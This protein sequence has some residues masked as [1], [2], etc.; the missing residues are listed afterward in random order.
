M[1]AEC[2]L[3]YRSTWLLCLLALEPVEGES[4]EI[5]LASHRRHRQEVKLILL[6]SSP[7]LGTTVNFGSGVTDL[8]QP[9]WS[10]GRC[11]VLEHRVSLLKCGWDTEMSQERQGRE[12]WSV[13]STGGMERS[14]GSFLCCLFQCCKQQ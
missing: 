2:C 13:V 8:G 3:F 11:G 12:R 6:F 10:S 7:V 1:L 4:R 14:R 9:S 5:I